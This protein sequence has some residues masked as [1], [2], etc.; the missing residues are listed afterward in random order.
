MPRP[1]DRIAPKTGAFLHAATLAIGESRFWAP[2]ERFLAE[3][4][5]PASGG[6]CGL[7]VRNAG[8]TNQLFLAGYLQGFAAECCQLIRAQLAASAQI[9]CICARMCEVAT[10]INLVRLE[11]S[12]AN[13][14]GMLDALDRLDGRIRLLKSAD[15][16]TLPPDIAEPLV[17][18]GIFRDAEF[19]RDSELAKYS[20]LAGDL[21]ACADHLERCPA[22]AAWAVELKLRCLLDR[23]DAEEALALCVEQ[24]GRHPWVRDYATITL[25]RTGRD[26]EALQVA[27]RLVG[28][29]PLPRLR[30]ILALLGDGRISEAVSLANQLAEFAAGI[31]EEPTLL[32][33][34]ALLREAGEALPPALETAD[35]VASCSRHFPAVFLAA[36]FLEI[37][38]DPLRLAAARDA[39]I[40]RS[41]RFTR[42]LSRHGHRKHGI[43]Q[44]PARSFG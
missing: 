14:V 26:R 17:D 2:I 13:L 3:L 18:G 16:A 1:S 23:A 27:G 43:L 5:A 33:A 15:P 12:R 4:G 39:L 25:L 30:L 22:G 35:R 7:F 37:E 21:E 40:D 28:H 29:Q 11:R 9:E 19:L 41:A 34:A 36:P 6:G 42:A 24:A 31:P 44:R 20:W 10:L 32:I 38:V 8:L